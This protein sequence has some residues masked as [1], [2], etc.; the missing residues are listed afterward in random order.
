MKVKVNIFIPGPIHIIIY[1]Y[2]MTSKRGFTT[3]KLCCQCVS[4]SF[5]RHF[6]QIFKP[7]NTVCFIFYVKKFFDRGNYLKHNVS[8]NIN[9]CKN[10]YC[11]VKKALLNTFF[12]FSLVG[13]T[14]QCVPDSLNLHFLFHQH[15]RHLILRI[16]R[17]IISTF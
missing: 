5:Q 3:P 11:M 9:I 2:Q 15:F 4:S 14:Q 13:L 6:L 1:E 7:V 10:I 8:I 12:L 17:L 16:W